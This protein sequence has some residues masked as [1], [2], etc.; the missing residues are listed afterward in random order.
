MCHYRRGVV[1]AVP[2]HRLVAHVVV[3]QLELATHAALHTAPAAAAALAGGIAAIPLLLLPHI[4]P[5]L[6]HLLSQILNERG[7]LLR[8]LL[9]LNVRILELMHFQDCG[10]V[11]RTLLLA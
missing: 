4:P 2:T 9:R 5:P 10:L 3:I 1:E 7:A 11:A 8:L 6:R